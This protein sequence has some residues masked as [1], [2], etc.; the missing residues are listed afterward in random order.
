MYTL[1]RDLFQ[2]IVFCLVA[3]SSFSKDFH[4][5]FESEKL[6]QWHSYDGSWVVKDQQYVVIS[7]TGGHSLAVGSNYVSFTYE[8]KITPSLSGNAGILFSVTDAA[9]GKDSF[10]GYY[11]A[12]NASKDSVYFFKVMNVL[13]YLRQDPLE[14]KARRGRNKIITIPYKVDANT[15]YNLKLIK[16]GNFMDLFINKDHVIS[17]VD[18]DQAIGSIGVMAD[19]SGVSFDDIKITEGPF[20]SFNWSWVK[21]AI[22]VPTNC[23]N[24]IQQWEEFD[25]IINDREL[26]YA[27]TYGINLV[28]IYLHY[29]VW[30]KDKAKFLKDLETFLTLADK[31]QIKTV[32]TFFDD[33][34]NPQPK[35]GP[36]PFPI[37]GRHNSQWAQ[38]PG[39]YIK[40]N[41]ATYKD[42]LKGYV[43]DVVNAHKEDCR[44]VFWEPYNEPGFNQ[45]GKYMEVTKILLNDSRL[46]IKD[47]GTMIPIT[48][49]ASP[50]FKGLGFSDFYSWHNY[51]KNYDGP[52][53]SE[54]INTECFNRQD[55]SIA[56]V[57]E[58]YGK[59]GTGYIIWELGIGRDNCRF[60]WDSPENA[61]E[62]SEPFQGLIYPDGHPWDTM[63]VSIIR[64][65]L[66][67]LNVFNVTYY[68]GNFSSEKKKSFSPLI[69]FD[70]GDEKGTGS[71]DASASIPKDHFAILW[72]GK[73]L[74]RDIGKYTFYIDTDNVASLWLDD[75]MIL[76]K[77]NNKREEVK[78]IIALEGNKSYKIKVKY[79][80]AKGDASMH[81][82][83]SGPGFS[84]TT[85]RGR[86]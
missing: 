63:E 50:D 2:L 51:T 36:Y 56:G 65:N 78:S 86:R 19:S 12:L 10:N 23:V 44:I 20:P 52:R 55:Q 15:V 45:H 74:T 53:G 41:Y 30:E 32:I 16:Q 6:E 82:H 77:K 28:R 38:C 60:H 62:V 35:L 18:K 26:Y 69:D 64:G 73:I 79:Y 81:L 25:P 22:F 83:W 37:P 66:D 4:D 49:T 1:V 8:I 70:L 61:P 27:H 13:Y 54:V 58:E 34:W 29:L 40:E 76:S 84:K 80:H 48:S 33:I 3:T 68:A 21:G 11:A 75:H 9:Y 57:V 14:H 46:W 67:H 7:P 43:Q 31:Y 17:I 42:K 24:Q 72:E 47:T 71:P 5:K 59:T 39:N 85:L